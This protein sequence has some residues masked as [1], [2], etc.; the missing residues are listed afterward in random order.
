MVDS[1]GIS[2]AFDNAPR[3]IIDDSSN[4]VIMSDC[5]RGTGDRDDNFADNQNTYFT[6]MSRYYD[7]GFTY[8][9]LG[10]GDELWD[11]RDFRLIAEANS[12]IFWLLGKFRSENRFHMVYGNHDIVKRSAKWRKDNLSTYYDE[13][14]KRD[15]PLFGDMDA[16]EG[17]ILTHGAAKRD[18]YLTHGHQGD[19]LNDGLWRLARFLVRYV[20]RPLEL[21]GVKDPTSTAESAEKR[22][23]VEERLSE[24]A[25]QNDAVLI[26]GHTHRPVFPKRGDPLYF[27]DG[28]CVHPRCITAIEITKGAVSLVKWG[29]ETR[30]DGTLS[31]G[32]TVLEGPVRL[33]EL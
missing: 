18:I 7:M 24:W 22:N 16:T 23:K 29:V 1:S 13:R 30:G 31:V 5:H 3:L 9:E 20:W 26:A 17:L 27:N 28:S 11:N 21:I 10:D 19:L 8:V 25:K 33:S 4:I 15:L 32:K 14:T 6:A 2:R 12:H